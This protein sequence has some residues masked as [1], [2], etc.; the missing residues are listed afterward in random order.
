MVLASR[1]SD[2]GF[3]CYFPPIDPGKASTRN[4]SRII[5]DSRNGRQNQPT[6]CM[7]MCLQVI[8]MAYVPTH[9]ADVFISYAHAEL[10]SLLP[11]ALSPPCQRPEH[12]GTLAPRSDARPLA[13]HRRLVGL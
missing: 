7:F 11:P 2:L 8:C 5:S 9:A 6:W 1:E 4:R 12:D 3:G 10:I 13:P